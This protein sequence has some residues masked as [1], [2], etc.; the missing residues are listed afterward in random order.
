[1]KSTLLRADSSLFVAPYC[2]V[3]LYF[4]IA[5]LL[6]GHLSRNLYFQYG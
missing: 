5:R 2:Q 1:M 3:K 4:M 6:L